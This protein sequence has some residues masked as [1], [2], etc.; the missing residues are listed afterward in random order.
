MS[1]AMI[2]TMLGGGGAA[3]AD[4][5][6]ERRRERERGRIWRSMGEDP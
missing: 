6:R 3:E 4:A 5:E 1:S 2:Q